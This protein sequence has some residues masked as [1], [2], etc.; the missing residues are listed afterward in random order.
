MSNAL[1]EF[2]HLRRLELLGWV[3]RVGPRRHR[4]DEDHQSAAGPV[5]T[6]S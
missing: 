1:L 5:D 3:L 4:S 2:D 6:P